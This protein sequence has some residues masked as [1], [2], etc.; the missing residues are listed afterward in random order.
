MKSLLIAALKQVIAFS[1]PKY[2]YHETLLE[3]M[4]SIK[5]DGL[6][7]RVGSI[8]KESYTFED[9]P[10]AG[11]AVFFS[12][13]E[14][15]LGYYIAWQIA[16]KL[17]KKDPKEITWEEIKEHGLLTVIDT[18]QHFQSLYPIY[19]KVKGDDDE[20]IDIDGNFVEYVEDENEK[21]VHMYDIPYSI[22]PGNWFSLAGA[23]PDKY[24]HGDELVRYLK[25]VSKKLDID[26]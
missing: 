11:G 20:V 12:E 25:R 16:N 21:E 4:A 6:T 7:P 26:D 5:K 3:N 1:K 17:G 19:Q 2:L 15:D 18:S 10:E 22:E 9:V 23:S 24:I 14:K 13:D 8:V